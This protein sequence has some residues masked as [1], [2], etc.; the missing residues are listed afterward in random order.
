MI[1]KEPTGEQCSKHV[2]VFESDLQLGYAIWYPQMGGYAGKAVALIDKG[3]KLFKNGSANGGCL[4]VYIW[5]DG[6]FP[7]ESD[8]SD[9]IIIHHCNPAQFIDFGTTLKRLN[10]A[11]CIKEGI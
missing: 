5:H 11:Q 8:V 10:D 9:A 7:F 6:Q 4:D 3:W 1:V 2:K